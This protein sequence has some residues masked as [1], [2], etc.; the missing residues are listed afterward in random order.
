MIR[1]KARARASDG[2]VG[3]REIESKLELQ[4][5]VSDKLREMRRLPRGWDGG[6]APPVSQEVTQSAYRTLERVSD[7]R[8]VFPFVTP[9]DEGSVLMEWRA[10]RERLELEFFPDE[11]PYIHYIDSEGRV[12]IN[13]PWGSGGIGYSEVRRSLKMLSSRIWVANPGWKKLFS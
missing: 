2:I 8:T 7:F 10:G 3:E 9:G 6:E 11:V 5:Y 4:M 1:R 13:G 12:R